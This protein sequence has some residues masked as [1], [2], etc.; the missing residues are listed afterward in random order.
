MADAESGEIRRNPLGIGKGEVFVELDLI[1]SSGIVE[2]RVIP[3]SPPG[4][5]RSRNQMTVHG[6]SRSTFP[7]AGVGA[8]EYS[9]LPLGNGES[10]GTPRW[11]V[12]D[13]PRPSG[14]RRHPAANR[15]RG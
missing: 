14:G 8:V 6:S 12:P 13:L 3:V 2:S 7:P 1:C 5:R 9:T 15:L 4:S 10:S 11:L